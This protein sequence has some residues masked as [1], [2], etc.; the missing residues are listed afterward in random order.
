MIDFNH[1][2]RRGH[3]YIPRPPG[4]L[5]PELGI[6]TVPVLVR[7]YL[8]HGD[9]PNPSWFRECIID[10]EFADR[11]PETKWK[12]AGEDSTVKWSGRLDNIADAEMPKHNENIGA[13]MW[14]LS[15]QVMPD[16]MTID[17]IRHDIYD[18][19]LANLRPLSKRG[20]SLNRRPTGAVERMYISRVI[21]AR[22]PCDTARPY[23]VD[24]PNK[25][26][27]KRQR[28]GQFATEREAVEVRDSMLE[29]MLP[30]DMYAI[31][32][33]IILAE[34]PLDEEGS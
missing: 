13:F 15:G 1:K 27:G 14:R 31:V 18:N 19:R 5:L 7:P 9:E 28:V 20:Q 12:L 34:P 11:V 6:K 21:T 23:R 30:D 10:I 16:G 32:M 26:T 3:N 8:R 4:L 25:H 2:E 24:I 33:P 17:H 29:S 22:W